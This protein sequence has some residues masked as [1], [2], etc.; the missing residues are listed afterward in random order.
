[1]PINTIQCK[2]CGNR[3]HYSV[4]DFKSEL[5]LTCN[6]CGT[7]N[8]VNADS[9][10]KHVADEIAMIEEEK[11]KARKL[12][13]ETFHPSFEGENGMPKS[14]WHPGSTFFSGE[15]GS[16]TMDKR[17]DALKEKLQSAKNELKDVDT[18][19]TRSSVDELINEYSTSDIDLSITDLDHSPYDKPIRNFVQDKAVTLIADRYLDGDVDAAKG[20]YSFMKTLY[21]GCKDQNLDFNEIANDYQTVYSFAT[22][23]DIS[24]NVLE[25]I[26]ELFQNG[27]MNMVVG[28]IGKYLK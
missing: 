27:T 14:N 20:F 10:S 6:R 17:L 24:P 5:S 25:I 26:D 1:M 13:E 3:I 4:N 11:A 9:I 2:Q 22:R 15:D 28:I 7:I 16:D 12:Q 8:C 23:L 18:H 19:F 21:Q